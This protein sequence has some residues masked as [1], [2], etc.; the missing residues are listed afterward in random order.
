MQ[1]IPAIQPIYNNNLNYH[2]SGFG[3]K[4]DQLYKSPIFHSGIDYAAPEGTKVYATADGVVILAANQRRYGNQ[5][6][7]KHNSD[8]QTRFAHLS[9]ISVNSGQRIKRGDVIGLVGNT[10]KSL[11]PHLHYEVI[12]RGKPV[13]PVNYFFLDLF[14]EDYIKIKYLANKTGL[15]LD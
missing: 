14:P 8:Y 5:I 9:E 13:N 15:S 3:K 7:I 2:V 11:I 4:I 1:Q 10:G 12:Y 6:I